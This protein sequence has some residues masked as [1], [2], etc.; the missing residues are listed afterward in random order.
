[1]VPGWQHEASS[2]FLLHLYGVLKCQPS[3]HGK[4]E[5]CDV[6]DPPAHRDLQQDQTN[7]SQTLHGLTCN[8]ACSLGKSGAVATTHIPSELLGLRLVEN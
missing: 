5:P 1:M 6:H 3:P 4:D 2:P 8:K 7:S